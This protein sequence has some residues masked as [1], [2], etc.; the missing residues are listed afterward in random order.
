MTTLNPPLSKE[1]R[2]TLA[3]QTIAAMRAAYEAEGEDG[4]FDEGERWLRED[5]TDAELQA[6]WDRWFAH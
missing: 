3:A 4:D 6:E 1:R 5:A 2:S